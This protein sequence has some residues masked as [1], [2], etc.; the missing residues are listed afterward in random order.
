MV[1]T[2]IHLHIRTYILL[3]RRCK[4]SC[5]QYKQRRN[6]IRARPQNISMSNTFNQQR[7]GIIQNPMYVGYAPNG[8]FFAPT[9]IIHPQY[10]PNTFVSP[11]IHPQAVLN[12][13]NVSNVAT[14]TSTSY[15]IYI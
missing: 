2:V 13:A 10:I 14:N 5:K 15:S 1:V 3:Y 7:S 6:E 12:N 8:H 4:E 9:N 11:S